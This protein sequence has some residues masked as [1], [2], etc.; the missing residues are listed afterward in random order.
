MNEP[1]TG[2]AG[3][4]VCLSLKGRHLLPLHPL[5]N[6]RCLHPHCGI[7]SGQLEPPSRA[8]SS[9]TQGKLTAGAQEG[10]FPGMRQGGA[11]RCEDCLECH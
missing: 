5:G 10:G 2:K 9:K 8:Q 3:T 11:G 7:S 4:G 6:S 1:G